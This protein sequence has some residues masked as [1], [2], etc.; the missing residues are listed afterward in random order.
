MP[1][2]CVP[3]T[4]DRCGGAKRKFI[5]QSRSAGVAGIVRS[6]GRLRKRI[7]DRDTPEVRRTDRS[8]IR[9]SVRVVR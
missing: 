8:P 1:S 7:R 3:K 9:A 5:N 2:A 6:V 4:V